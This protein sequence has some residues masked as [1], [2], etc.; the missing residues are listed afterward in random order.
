M[1]SDSE[2][3]GFS[4]SWFTDGEML[5]TLFVQHRVRIVHVDDDAPGLSETKRPLQQAAFTT[6]GKMA[7]IASRPAA[8]FG[9]NEFVVLPEGAIEESQIAFIHGALPAISEP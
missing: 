6:E 3:S 8:A 9:G 4:T 2:S 5:G 7:H 1:N